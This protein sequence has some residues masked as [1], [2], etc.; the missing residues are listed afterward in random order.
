[1]SEVIQEPYGPDLHRRVAIQHICVTSSS[2]VSHLDVLNMP[3]LARVVSIV[4]DEGE[5]TVM[6]ATSSIL[7]PVKCGQTTQV[8]CGQILD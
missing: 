8:V 4:F 1:M 3:V 6:V 7:L 5:K 2:S